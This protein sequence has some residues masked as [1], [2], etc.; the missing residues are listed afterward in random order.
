MLDHKWEKCYN[1]PSP[2]WV[3]QPRE[4][5]PG[6]QTPR[7]SEFANQW[8]LCSGELE[9]YKKLRLHSYRA[10]AKSHILLVPVQGSSLKEVWVRPDKGTRPK[11]SKRTNWSGDKQAW[12]SIQGHNQKDDQT[13]KRMDEYGENF[14]KEKIWRT[15]QSWR[16]QYLKFKNTVE[17]INSKLN[18]TKE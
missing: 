8:D 15:K 12:K 4:P 2:T 16:I 10:R 3:P 7:T 14:N 18:D 1:H 17:W 9:G 11:F 5:A 6:R 13:E